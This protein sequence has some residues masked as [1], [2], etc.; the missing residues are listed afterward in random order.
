MDRTMPCIHVADP[1]HHFDDSWPLA[2]QKIWVYCR[3]CLSWSLFMS[4]CFN[5]SSL[6]ELHTALFLQSSLASRP[7]DPH[8]TSH[9]TEFTD[10]VAVLELCLSVFMLSV[11]PKCLPGSVSLKCFGPRLQGKRMLDLSMQSGS[12]HLSPL[13]CFPVVCK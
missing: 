12:C 8:H 7:F 11:C 13:P 3:F 1:H 2:S 6:I 4:M 9:R 10:T 5:W